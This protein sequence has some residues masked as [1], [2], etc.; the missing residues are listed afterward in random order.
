MG[1][2]LHEWPLVLFTAFAQTIVGAFIALTLVLLVRQAQS[3][4]NRIHYAM[5]ILW[6]LMA[7]S[8][9]FSTMHLGS[10]HRAFNAL[11]RV[12]ASD[13]SNEIATGSLFFALGGA[14]WLLA[15]SRYVQ[16]DRQNR[17]LVMRWIQPL[18]K[19]I[20][21]IEAKLPIGWQGVGRIIVCVAGL[22]F[23]SAMSKLYM[24]PTVPTWNVVYT[25]LS[26]FLTVIISGSALAVVLLQLAKVDVLQRPLVLIAVIGAIVAGVMILMQYQ[27]LLET[28]TAIFHAI[29]RVPAYVPLMIARFALIFFGLVCLY[30]SLKSAQLSMSLIGAALILAGELIARTIFYGLHM[31]VGLKSLG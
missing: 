23:I 15:T 24:I 9:V 16:N 3:A 6:G 12:G 13:L 29:D 31:T 1:A 5:V 11:N 19:V 18:A 21:G 8:F 20:G 10:P 26:F 7:L 14:Y 17:P 25:P 22:I 30:R 4:T 28:N 2:G 27:F